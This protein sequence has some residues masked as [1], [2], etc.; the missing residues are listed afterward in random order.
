MATSKKSAPKPKGAKPPG[1][2]VAKGT[3]AKG[4]PVQKPVVTKPA[5]KPVA[6]KPAASKPTAAPAKPSKAA[7][8]K[9]AAALVEATVGP[10]KGKGKGGGPPAAVART[11]E[12]ISAVT[13]AVDFDIVVRGASGTTTYGEDT[14]EIS[15][16]PPTLFALQLTAVTTRRYLHLIQKDASDQIVLLAVID[17]SGATR[18][19]PNPAWQRA[20]VDGTLHL[21]MSDLLLSRGDIVS[22]IGGHEPPPTDARPPYI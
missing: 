11:V 10:K 15:I 5:A 12:E 22:V 2:P 3:P 16:A 21:L 19:P 8:A 6:P 1:K 7:P 14:N 20:V 9:L 13:E 4:V 17:G 18:M